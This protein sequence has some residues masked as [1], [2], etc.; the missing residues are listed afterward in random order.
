MKKF[1]RFSEITRILEG[2]T[3]LRLKYMITFIIKK[4]MKNRIK[5]TIHSYKIGY[6]GVLHFVHIYFL[7]KEENEYFLEIYPLQK[8]DG[9]QKINDKV[10]LKED[11]INNLLIKEYYFYYQVVDGKLEDWSSFLNKKSFQTVFYVKSFIK[12]LKQKIENKKKKKKV[13]KLLIK[14]NF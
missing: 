12:K 5:K 6:K 10:S 13:K 2:K 11:N 14:I 9:D 8:Y 4:W 3:M 1:D 7:K